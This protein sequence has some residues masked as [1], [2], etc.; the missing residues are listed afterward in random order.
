MNE[1]HV[2]TE[3]YDIYILYILHN[4]DNNNIYTAIEFLFQWW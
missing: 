2:I 1:N 3:L 4:N